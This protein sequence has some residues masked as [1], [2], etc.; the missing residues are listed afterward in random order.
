[1][2]T[3]DYADGRFRRDN[4]HREET[5][6]LARPC[7]DADNYAK[8]LGIVGVNTGPTSG[9]A[10]LAIDS[11]HLND[12]GRVHGG[13]LFSLADAAIALAA[14]AAPGEVAVVTVGQIQF[15]E[16]V[17][18]DDHLVAIAEREFRRRRRAGYRVRVMRGDE[19]VALG[20]GETIAIPQPPVK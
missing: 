13:A 4:D 5:V 14:N 20:T 17:G 3:D 19:L 1:V 2:I 7:S 10:E 11:R 15:V 12:L 6:A 18:P 8:H 16:A 9:R